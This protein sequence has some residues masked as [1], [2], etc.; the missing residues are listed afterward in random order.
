MS[1]AF[2][3]FTQIY[4]LIA[5]FK[6]ANLAPNLLYFKFSR[7]FIRSNLMPNLT[8]VSQNLT[9]KFKAAIR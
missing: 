8:E 3:I 4:R 1:A 5:H 7:K 9:L 2:K 6:V